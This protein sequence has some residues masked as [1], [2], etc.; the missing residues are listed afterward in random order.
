MPLS[1]VLA[2]PHIP[3]YCGLNLKSQVCTTNRLVHTLAR[4]PMDE[5]PLMTDMASHIQKA[6]APRPF[7]MTRAC[8][9]T[10]YSIEKGVRFRSNQREHVFVACD[11][12][13]ICHVSCPSDEYVYRRTVETG[14]RFLL[15]IPYS[16]VESR[17]EHVGSSM[18]F[19]LPLDASYFARCHTSLPYFTV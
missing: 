12:K 19:P 14:S 1:E 2:L 16:Q 3:M 10:L 7:E 15:S 18:G 9:L 8:T 11:K 6:G 17:I 13:R 5:T 4:S